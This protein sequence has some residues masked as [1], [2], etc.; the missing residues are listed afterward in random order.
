MREHL[1]AFAIQ[2]LNVTGNGTGNI[3]GGFNNSSPMRF[4]IVIHRSRN[5]S[6]ITGFKKALCRSCASPPPTSSRQKAKEKAET[7]MAAIAFIFVYAALGTD[8]FTSS[9]PCVS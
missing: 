5:F 6:N 1:P 4:A 2:S 3:L 9:K 8:V 7:H